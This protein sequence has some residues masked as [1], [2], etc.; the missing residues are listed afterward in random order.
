[1]EVV[2]EMEK[3]SISKRSELASLDTS[4]SMMIDD[5]RLREKGKFVFWCFRGLGLLRS[6]SGGR[7]TYREGE[8]KAATFE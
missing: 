5:L 8:Q 3:L 2:C 6:I 4:S 7:K 1:M